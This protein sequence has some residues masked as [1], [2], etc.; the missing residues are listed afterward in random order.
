MLDAVDACAYVRAPDRRLSSPATFVF[1]GVEGV[2]PGFGGVDLKVVLF[3]S[4]NA[5]ESWLP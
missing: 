5:S 3:R 4:R 2:D 1:G